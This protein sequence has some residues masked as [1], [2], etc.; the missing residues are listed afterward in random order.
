[1]HQATTRNVPA[2]LK[3]N[4]LQTAMAGMGRL[5]DSILA[6]AETVLGQELPFKTGRIIVLSGPPGRGKSHLVEAFANELTERSPALAEKIFFLR[7]DLVHYTY[8]LGSSEPY[9]ADRPIG[10]IDDLF[11]EHASIDRLGTA[12]D[13]PV[14]HG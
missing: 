8:S 13:F 7:R 1:M 14:W 12:N 2:N 4:A 5:V 3:D 11:R 10:I 6:H 9:F